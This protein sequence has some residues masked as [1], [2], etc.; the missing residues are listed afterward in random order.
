M[1]WLYPHCTLLFMLLWMFKSC[2]WRL[3]TYSV[4]YS[5]Y[6]LNNIFFFLSIIFL[7]II[8]LFSQAICITTS[9]Y[10]G[11]VVQTTAPQLMQICL[12]SEANMVWL[13]CPMSLILVLIHRISR[14]IRGKERVWFG[15]LRI[16]SL[17]FADHV[18]LLASS[19]HDLQQMQG[20]FEVRFEVIRMRVSTS[21]SEA[22]VLC[23]KTELIALWGWEW[24]A[25]QSDGLQV[26]QSWSQV[27]VILRVRSTGRLVQNQQ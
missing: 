15:D 7:K 19:D 14:H 26:S 25:A 1:S 22:V 18:V 2:F 5:L 27:R 21:N 20:Q 16:A 10:N 9:N 17:L 24:V 8:K 4:C 3:S 11:S 23:W 6:K 12:Y 13:G